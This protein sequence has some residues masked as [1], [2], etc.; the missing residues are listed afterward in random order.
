MKSMYINYAK[1]SRPLSEAEFEKFLA[2][3]REER[4][5]RE[6]FPETYEHK[7]KMR[8]YRQEALEVWLDKEG[9]TS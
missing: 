1:I 6:A 8:R 4:K 9:F 2:E 3:I 7:Q 5:F